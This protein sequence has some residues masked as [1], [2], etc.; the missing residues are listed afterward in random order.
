MTE[1]IPEKW[2]EVITTTV[3]KEQKRQEHIASKEQHD[4]RFR[5]TEL[6]VKNYRKL[7][8]HCENLPEHIQMTKEELE[9]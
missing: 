6:L 2:I 1:Q 3:L 5:N 4:R 9:A 8:A 7:S